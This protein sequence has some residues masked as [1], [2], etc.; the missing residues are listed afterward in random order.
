VAD[1]RA[2]E[3]E[4]IPA[5]ER[6]THGDFA[7]TEAFSDGVFAIAVTLLVIFIDVPKVPNDAA[8]D[9]AVSDLG[10][11]VLSYFIG[12]FVI[13]LFWIGHH[14]FF[15]GLHRFDE[16]LMFVN[17]AYLSAVAFVPFTTGLF[18]DYPDA[19]IALI[20]FATAVA[21]VS[22]LDTLMLYLA[23][24]WELC[25]VPSSRAIRVQT[26]LA[27]FAPGIVFGLSIPVAFVS[28]DVAQWVWPVLLL[29]PRLW[30]REHR[31]RIRA[32]HQG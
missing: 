29:G 23:F 22:A 8:L 13:A 11:E 3:Q 1:D 7:R 12:F 17:L 16:R 24:R 6:R 20:L 30:P 25:P 21:A 9:E 18:G 32:S 28:T 19:R 2:R 10:P 14:R 27:N 26:M 5:A 31:E 15:A 4:R